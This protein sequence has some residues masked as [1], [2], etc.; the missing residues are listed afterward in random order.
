[1]LITS[2]ATR[3]TVGGAQHIRKSGGQPGQV[4]LEL[5]EHPQLTN[6]DAGGHQV[7]CEASRVEQLQRSGVHGEG[8]GEV[9]HLATALQYRAAEA[10]SGKVAGQH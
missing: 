2:H 6:P 5:A 10:G 7:I 9:G 4:H 1:M 3:M 8:A